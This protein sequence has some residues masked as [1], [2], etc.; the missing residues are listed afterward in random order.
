MLNFNVE[1]IN[2]SLQE[3]KRYSRNLILKEVGIQGQKRL[4]VATVL[5][6]GAGGL[7]T[8]LLMYLSATGIGCIGIVDNDFVSLSNLQRQVLYNTS[9]IGT[10]KVQAAKLQIQQINPNCIVHT[11]AT[12][13][14]YNNA[15]LIIS[16][17]DIIVD[18]TDNFITRYLLSDVCSLLNKPLVYGAILKN[19]GHVSVFNYRGGP[20]Y[21]D[22]YP[23]SPSPNSVPSCGEGGIFPGLAAIIGTLQ[24]NEVIKIILGA[25]V[26][27]SGEMLVYDFLTTKFS[28]LQINKAQSLYRRYFL[29]K[30]NNSLDSF[31]YSNSTRDIMKQLEISQIVLSEKNL[32][33]DVR[34]SQ[35]YN[36]YHIQ[37]AVNIPLEELRMP[38][39]IER[40]NQEFN[41]GKK[42]ILYCQ[43]N[44][45]SLAA[46][47]ILLN[48]NLIPYRLRGGIGTVL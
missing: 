23:I 4:K 13:L 17:Y 26:V 46:L 25:G 14:N 37:D 15:V 32:L 29:K 45:R 43:S 24:S 21:R 6:I 31:S 30:L 38:K 2:L 20:N 33:V 10:S 42:I 27:L 1:K 28:R 3:Y 9:F 19:L 41:I 11:Y 39:N 44:S 5:C 16:E 12:K 47:V 48:M 7:A 40:L 35:E 18:A 34:T 36:L 22:L 8:P